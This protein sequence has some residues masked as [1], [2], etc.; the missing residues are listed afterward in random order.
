MKVVRNDLS[1]FLK[2]IK[3]VQKAQSEL[4]ATLAE[5]GVEIAETLY[6]ASNFHPTIEIEQKNAN[7]ASIVFNHYAIALH[8]FGTGAYSAY[9]DNNKL[10]KSGVPITGKWTYY[11]DSPYK[12]TKNGKKGWYFNKTFTVGEPAHA[13]IYYTAR[14]LKKNIILIA[15]S[16]IEE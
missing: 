11:Y 4:T 13:E 7:Q 2:K 14:E 1:R 15:K 8:E 9:P 6:S 10:P 3:K 12:T 5:M 16:I